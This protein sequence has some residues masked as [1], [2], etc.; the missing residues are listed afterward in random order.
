[1]FLL[2][3][4]A[5]QDNADDACLL[6]YSCLIPG[7]SSPLEQFDLSRST[8]TLQSAEEI[9]ASMRGSVNGETMVSPNG[10]PGE[11]PGGPSEVY[12]SV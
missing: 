5:L 12:W 8:L 9:V 10:E 6:I 2:W 3:L 11:K 1:M 4:Q 7:I